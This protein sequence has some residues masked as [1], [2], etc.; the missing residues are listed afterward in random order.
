MKSAFS[1]FELIIVILILS[2]LVSFIV[3]NVS[4]SLDSSIKVK[5]KSEIALIRNSISK[6]KTKD[7]LLGKANLIVLDDAPV[8]T[9]KSKLFNNILDFSLTSTSTQYKLVGDWIKKT[10][11][12]YIIY[13]S[14]DTI[15][16]FKLED[17]S[18]NCK[19]SISLCKEFE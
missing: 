19:S 6:Y 1:L 13:I 18:F 3:I 15:L 2:I 7:I 9:N 16:K 8:D 14:K 12:E 5:I 4:S 11:S 10:S 17:K